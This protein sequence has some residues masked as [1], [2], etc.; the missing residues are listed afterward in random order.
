MT[1]HF[2]RAASRPRLTDE[3]LEKLAKLAE[4]IEISGPE[5]TLVIRNGASQIRLSADGTISV[6]GKRIL[7][8]AEKN[9]AL[10]AAWI[11]LN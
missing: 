11:D 3:T 5:G 9:V 1:S 7:Q 6:K 8:E 2:S 10:R 4:M